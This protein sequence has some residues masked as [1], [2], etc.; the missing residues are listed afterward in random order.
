[1][2]LKPPLNRV[3]TRNLFKSLSGRRPIEAAN[4][5]QVANEEMLGTLEA[6]ME[7]TA[8]T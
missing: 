4:A 3:S 8:A 7:M 5:K 6:G 2:V 1:M